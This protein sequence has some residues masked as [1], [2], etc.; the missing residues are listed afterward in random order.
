MNTLTIGSKT[1]GNESPC[2]IIAEGGLNH[3][4]NL[5]LAARMIEEAADCGADAVKFQTYTTHELFPP[6]HPEWNRFQQMVFNRE[7]YERL[8]GIADEMGILFL[9]TPF[10]EASSD[11]LET[12][13]VPAFKVG[14]GEVTHLTF[15]NYL[16]EKGK[17]MILSTGMSTWNELDAAVQTIRDAGNESFCLLH[18]VSAYPCPPEEANVR[19]VIALRE[20]YNILTGF[21]DHTKTDTAALAS[22]ALGACVIEKHFTLSRNLPGWDHFFS[23]D[24]N[25]FKRFVDSI[26]ELEQALG[27]GEKRI[28]R[29]EEPIHAIARRS[30][31][32]RK[33]IKAGDIITPDIVIVRRP[34]GPLSADCLPELL[35]KKI[36]RDIPAGTPLQPGDAQ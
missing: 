28:T 25:Q 11:L 1:I 12:I 14:S 26:R 27:T 6:N 15:L 34:V 21:S 16:A 29:S 10:D 19:M 13:G 4:G 32:A 3:N 36:Q 31:Y 35:G 22:I 9:S 7:E 20:R 23:Y 18:C 33:D 17:P 8:R 24:P 30:I 5:E 2:F